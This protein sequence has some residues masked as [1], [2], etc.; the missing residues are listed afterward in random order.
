VGV[1][2]LLLVLL[3]PLSVWGAIRQD[4]TDTQHLAGPAGGSPGS[5]AVTLLQ[6]HMLNATPNAAK[7]LFQYHNNA[8]GGSAHAII[9]YTQADGTTVNV[10]TL[11]NLAPQQTAASVHSAAAGTWYFF[12]VVRNRSTIQLYVGSE[13]S[14]V[15]LV[16]T[17]TD[18]RL[19]AQSTAWRWTATGTSTAG[20]SADASIERLKVYNAALDRSRIEAERCSRTPASRVGL[21]SYNEF[22]M[23]GSYV[24]QDGVSPWVFTTQ[25]GGNFSTVAGPHPSCAGV[26]APSSPFSGVESTPWHR[27]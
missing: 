14:A 11:V 17:L 24:G 9:V 19:Q 15:G 23:A 7:L 2:G 4:G 3:L 20:Y 6:W 18:P 26:A 25:G 16:A 13:G 10:S 27:R 21:W 8:H 22:V 1:S 5:G 12:G